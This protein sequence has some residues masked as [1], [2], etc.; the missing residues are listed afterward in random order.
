MATVFSFKNVWRRW[1]AEFRVLLYIKKATESE[2]RP[3]CRRSV[4]KS[5]L[6]ILCFDDR[7]YPFPRNLH[8]VHVYV[9][10]R[11]G[12][13]PRFVYE[14]LLRSRAA[15]FRLKLHSSYARPAPKP[16]PMK[17]GQA[18][19]RNRMTEKTTPNPRPMLDLTRRFDRQRSHWYSHKHVSVFK[20]PFARFCVLLSRAVWGD[21]LP[22]R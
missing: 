15:C 7:P 21:R 5:V 12:L 4:S 3:K 1:S 10:L 8:F 11:R 2:S 13:S 22:F 17:A 6:Q 19:R 18:L 14:L 20:N 9:V 16:A